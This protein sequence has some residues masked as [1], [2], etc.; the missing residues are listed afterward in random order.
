MTTYADIQKA[1]EGSTHP[2]VDDHI[3]AAHFVATARIFGIV[4]TYLLNGPFADPDAPIV[5]R[6]EWTEPV[7]AYSGSGLKGGRLCGLFTNSE[8]AFQTMAENE[9]T[10]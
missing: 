10:R 9:A 3:P 4:T 8:T 7:N 1:A 6:I 2:T 5:G